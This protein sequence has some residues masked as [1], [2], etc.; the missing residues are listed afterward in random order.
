MEESKSKKTT[1][2]NVINLEMNN[3]IELVALLYMHEH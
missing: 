2:L 3:G 1:S